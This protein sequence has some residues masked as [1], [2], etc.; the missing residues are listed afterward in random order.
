MPEKETGRLRGQ[1]PDMLGPVVAQPR[2]ARQHGGQVSGQV[3]HQV[4]E[5]AR[6]A[7]EHMLQQLRL[8]V[9]ACATSALPH[10]HRHISNM[11]SLVTMIGAPAWS[12]HPAVNNNPAHPYVSIYI[13]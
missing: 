2:G 12:S 4:P 8:S 5:Q 11:A 10:Q 6:Q 9:R 3:A 1:Q 13:L 7:D